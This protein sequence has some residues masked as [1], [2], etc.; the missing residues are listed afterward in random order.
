MILRSRLKELERQHPDLKKFD[1]LIQEPSWE[2]Y[3]GPFYDKQAVVTAEGAQ[4]LLLGKGRPLALKAAEQGPALAA[5]TEYLRVYQPEGWVQGDVDHI[6]SR[7][8]PVAR[9]SG[10]GVLV[11]CRAEINE[12]VIGSIAYG[13]TYNR[14]NHFI[15]I[16]YNGIPYVAK[17]LHFLKVPHPN[18]SLKLSPLR[19]PIVMFYQPQAVA[20]AAA[21]APAA[22]RR[23]QRRL[24]QQPA[25][26]D[27]LLK[28]DTRRTC[29]G[30]EYSAVD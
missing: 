18:A 1:L 21:A 8:S 28:I 26:H 17:V 13:R 2:K 14:I 6:F 27:R 12:E 25:A 22:G 9:A 23:A 7:T 24:P 16:D 10:R 3:D 30:Y 19:L 15:Q 11:F 4:T 29:P 5:V 20:Q